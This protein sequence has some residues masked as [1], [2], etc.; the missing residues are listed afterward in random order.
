MSVGEAR[1]WRRDTRTASASD[2]L[3]LLCESSVCQRPAAAVDGRAVL[4]FF[5]TVMAIKFH[6]TKQQ[7]LQSLSHNAMP[8]RHAS[9]VWSARREQQN[10][11]LCS[12]RARASR[13]AG[14]ENDA[15]ERCRESDECN[16]E[17]E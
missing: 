4:F 16:E 2:C 5:L 14:R 17:D 3:L 15:R 13:E 7:K 9:Q 6:K 12:M 8:Q 11:R 10:G 1:T